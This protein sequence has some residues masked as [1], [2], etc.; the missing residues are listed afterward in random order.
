MVS[1]AL[2]LAGVTWGLPARWHPDEKADA[3]ARMARAGTLAPDSFINPSLSLYLVWPVVWAQTRAADAGLLSGTA[4]D[5]LIAGRVLSALAGAAAVCVLG[6]AAASVRRG[7]GLLAAALLAVA[8]GV[9]NLCHF[10]TPE[11]WLLLGSSV[12]LLFAIEHARGQRGVVPLAIAL[13]LTAGTKYTAAALLVPCLVAIWLSP[14]SGAPGRRDSIAVGA[15]GLVLLLLGIGL[16]SA[17]G[18]ALAAHL[19]LDDV[20][21]LRP[22]SA[23]VFVRTIAGMLVAAGIALSLAAAAAHRGARWALR[24][25]RAD[26]VLLV[27]GAGLAFAATTPYA[28]IHPLAFLSDLAFNQQTRHEYKGLVGASTS[29]GPY[30]ALLA[31]AVTGPLAVAAALGVL[32]GLGR[33]VK[34][35]RAVA[36]V[37]SAAVAPYLLVASSGHQ[38][39]RF[40]VPALPA[41]LL[42]AAL[43]LRTLPPPPL[44]AAL[45]GLV[46]ARAAL[47]ALLVVRLFFVDS[48]YAAARW[49][50]AHVP[51]TTPVDLITNNPG[52]GPA[53]PPGRARLVPTLSREMAP[54]DRFAAA[55]AA[56]RAEGAPWLVLTAS[57]YERFLDHPDQAPERAAFFR[58]LLEGRGGYEVAV[59]FRQSGWRR[60]PAEFLDPEIVVLKR[61]AEPAA[62]LPTR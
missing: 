60:P 3:V 5:P 2:N 9:V 4:A 25:V 27:L 31:D 38:A 44:R 12:T 33:A 37:V 13:G 11:P 26:I 50:D 62:Q 57:Y 14:K 18:D 48:R 24:L 21:L 39:M 42:L 8:P 15:A 58:D 59:R 43:A 35:D 49:L 20:R 51:A 22:E 52:Y 17:T 16:V 46:L 56:Y 23:R 54:P 28:A 19:R 47:G 61:T 30:F 7:L 45:A 34:G 40:L 6:L 32:V 29:F 10:A 55:A 41:A 1:L 36:V 53:L